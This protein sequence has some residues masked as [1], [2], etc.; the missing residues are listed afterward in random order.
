M[1]DFFLIKK[2]VDSQYISGRVVNHE[3]I[4]EDFLNNI[5]RKL[6]NTT[7]I[8]QLIFLGYIP[9]LYANDS[10]E[11]TL[12]SKLVEVF[13]CEWANRMGYVGKYVKQKSSY[14]DVNIVVDGR[15]IVADAK[16][17]RLGRSQQAP[18]VKDFVKPEDYRKWIARHNNRLGGLVAYPCTHEWTSRSDAYKYCSSNNMPIVMLPYKLLAFLLNTKVKYKREI[19]ISPLWEYSKIFPSEV[20]C[21]TDYWSKMFAEIIKISQTS[22]KEM[23]EFLGYA[24]SLIHECIRINMREL[25]NIK[26]TILSNIQSEVDK[27][28]S[29][30]ELKTYLISCRTDNETKLINVLLDRI[31]KFRLQ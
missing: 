5:L 24:D 20:N 17:F 21:R 12:Y 22:D 28:S 3:D 4:A 2:Y 30:E 10:S 8:E 11:E 18:N 25:E 26:Q 1:A 9:D 29:V 15:T 13:L 14:E 23:R 19:D 31:S 6:D 7:F 27:I 16:S